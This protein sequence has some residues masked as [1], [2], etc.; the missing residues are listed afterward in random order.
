MKKIMKRSIL[1]MVLVTGLIVNAENFNSPIK[2]SKVESKLINLTLSNLSDN[3]QLEIKD[4]E[5]IILHSEN[6]I[7]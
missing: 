3:V 1:S 6:V 7:A 2:V 4:G 5:G